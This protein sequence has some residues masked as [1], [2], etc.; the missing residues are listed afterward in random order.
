MPD[1]RSLSR[2]LIREH[3]DIVPT[4]VGNHFKDLIPVFTG[5]PGFR[6]EFIPMKIGAGMTM[7]IEAAINKQT[8]MNPESIRGNDN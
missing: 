3:P 5:N 2:T 8:P 6:L 1:L 4:K 7:L